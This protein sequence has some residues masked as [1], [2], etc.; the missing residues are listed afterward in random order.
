MKICVCY[1]ITVISERLGQNKREP[2]K[3]SSTKLDSVLPRDSWHMGPKM[4]ATICRIVNIRCCSFLFWVFSVV[5]SVVVH[6][7]CGFCICVVAFVFVL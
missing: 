6:F 5:T 3:K 7:C 2:G 4:T 1:L